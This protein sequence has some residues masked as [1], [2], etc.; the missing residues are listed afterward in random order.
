M[1]KVLAAVVATAFVLSTPFLAAQQEITLRGEVVDTSCYRKLGVEKG[2][3]AG[4][5]ACAKD[6]AKKGQVL[7]I[8]TDGDGQLKITG[9]YAA[10][11]NAKLIDYIGKQ[12]EVKGTRDRHTDYST[13]IRV[14]TITLVKKAS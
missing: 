3:G 6:C 13:A 2:T 5:V 8:L 7:G 11:N 9:D 14:T 1:R 10:N 4:H 12:V